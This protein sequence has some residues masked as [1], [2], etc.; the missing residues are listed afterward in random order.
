ML[1]HTVPRRRLL[2]SL[3]QVLPGTNKAFDEL[4]RQVF[5]IASPATLAKKRKRRPSL[6]YFRTASSLLAPCKPKVQSLLADRQT[7]D[8]QP[9][10]AY[11]LCVLEACRLPSDKP[12]WLGTAARMF[13][14]Q[15]A[16]RK[17]CSITSPDRYFA[18]RSRWI[19]SRHQTRKSVESHVFL[20]WVQDNSVEHSAAGHVV[21][22]G[23]PDSFSLPPSPP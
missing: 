8:S 1:R 3:V 17:A 11:T 14:D 5:S 15:Q 19:A 22:C 2:P 7:A 16:S 9:F 12:V 23:L 4:T 18:S 21:G 6:S 13:S 20:V 10:T